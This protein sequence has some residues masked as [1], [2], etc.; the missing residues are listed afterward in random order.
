[1]AHH[2]VQ[3]SD[4]G[5][6]DESTA[7]VRKGPDMVQVEVLAESGI[8]KN[9]T[10]YDKGATVPMSRAAAI[11]FVDAGEAAWIKE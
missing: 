9:G 4:G 5:S 7:P 2:K 10:H 6:V 8:F 3:V 1:M 11:L